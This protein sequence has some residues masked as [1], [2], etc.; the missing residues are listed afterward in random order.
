MKATDIERVRTLSRQ[1]KDRAASYQRKAD[2]AETP[3]DA[4]LMRTAEHEDADMA[5][6]LDAVLERALKAPEE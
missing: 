2:K 3:E 1:Y 4:A 6:A 5:R